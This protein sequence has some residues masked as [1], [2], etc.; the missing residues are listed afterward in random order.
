MVFNSLGTHPI[1]LN[2]DRIDSFVH[3]DSPY[4]NNCHS[5]VISCNEVISKSDDEESR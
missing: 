3:S 1:F 5:T 4:N 2:I